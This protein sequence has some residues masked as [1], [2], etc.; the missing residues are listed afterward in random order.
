MALLLLPL[1]LAALVPSGSGNKGESRG[2]GGL[3]AG[4]QEEGVGVGVAERMTGVGSLP[5]PLSP[6]RV[7]LLPSAPSPPQY[8][9]GWGGLAPHGSPTPTSISPCWGH[10]VP[11]R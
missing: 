3:T 10:L 7:S 1:V 11:Q 2:A 4:S 6:P 9:E 8:L 5:H